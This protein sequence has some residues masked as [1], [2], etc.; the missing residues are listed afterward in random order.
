MIVPP[1]RNQA[2]RRPP[3]SLA[4]WDDQALSDQG[5]AALGKAVI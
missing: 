4:T 3:R 2:A 5:T 1:L